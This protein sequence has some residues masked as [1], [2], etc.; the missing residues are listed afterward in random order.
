MTASDDIQ[1]TRWGEADSRLVDRM[2]A[3]DADAIASLQNRFGDELRLF[4]R[5]MLNDTA[6]AEDV[7]QE[8]F[9]T[10]CRLTP[11]QQP[12]SSLRGWLY[13]IARRRCIDL[14]RRRKQP[15][16]GDVRGTR[17]AQPT[18]DHAI[19]PLTTPA[20]K[21]LKLDRAAKVLELVHD[22]DEELKTV[23]LMRYFQDLPREEIAEA[24]GLTVAGVK[25]RLNKAMQLLRDKMSRLDDS[26][27]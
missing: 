14:H 2:R 27:T 17:P 4:C 9:L 7:V 23:V 13:Q 18:F 12:T 5:R 3:G 15:E 26:G 19:D 6:L 25:A 21:A 22:L 1:A 16:P 11:E 10:C 20:G 8:I 24:V